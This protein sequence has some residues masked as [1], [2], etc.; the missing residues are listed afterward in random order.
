MPDYG[1]LYDRLEEYVPDTW[2]VSWSHK[3]WH[4]KLQLKNEATDSDLLW[5]RDIHSLQNVLTDQLWL[6]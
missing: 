5:G 4:S 1:T 2:C 6:S 3:L